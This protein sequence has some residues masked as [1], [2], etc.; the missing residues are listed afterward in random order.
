MPIFTADQLT[1]IGRAI[2]EAAGTPPDEAKLTVEMLVNSDLCGYSSHGVMQIPGY[3]SKILFGSCKPGSEI[4]IVRDFGAIAVVDGGWGLGQVVATKTMQLAIEKAKQYGIGAIGTHN[5]HHIGRMADYVSMAICY[6]MIGFCTTTGFP[7]VAP[8]GGIERIFNQN[9][10]GIGVPA[11]KES[12]YVLDISTSVC[13]GGKIDVALASGQSLP[14][15]YIIDKHGNPTVD[16][17]DYMNG[18]AILPFGGPVAYKG[19]GLSLAVDIIAGILCGRGSAFDRKNKGQ[20]ILQMAIKINVFQQIDVFKDNM[21]RLIR[22]VKNSKKAP[23]FKEILIP[24][25][26]SLKNREKKMKKGIDISQ[27]VWSRILDTAK[28]VN[29][30]VKDLLG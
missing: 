20:G 1:R 2:F 18:G 26:G 17:K 30:N 28:K 29:I 15:G 11:G 3:V 27:I 10:I 13:A 4:H 6:D 22:T 9:P 12:S 14:S 24:G 25:E 16:P 7:A 8:Y 19:Y 21:D 5:C 23:G